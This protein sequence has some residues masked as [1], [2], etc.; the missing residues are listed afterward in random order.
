MAMVH[1]Y[2]SSTILICIGLFSLQFTNRLSIKRTKILKVPDRVG[3]LGIILTENHRV[4]V[5]FERFNYNLLIGVRPHFI[6]F[7]LPPDLRVIEFFL[8]EKSRRLQTFRTNRRKINGVR[9]VP[10][11]FC[12][13]HRTSST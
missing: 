6:F 8:P 4:T 1:P 5:Q 9:I 13:I 2:K 3:V 11:K 7:Y 10:M 12:G